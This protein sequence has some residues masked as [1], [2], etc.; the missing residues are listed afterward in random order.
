M[1]PAAAPVAAGDLFRGISAIAAEE[2]VGRVEQEL[3]EYFGTEAAFLVSSGK[4]ALA[5]IL[6]GLSRLSPRRRVVI[7]AYTCYSVPSAVLK[8]GLA[9][10][11]CDVDPDT[12]DFDFSALE[13]LADER[14]LCVLPTHLFGIPSDVAR[15]RRICGA[16]G[17]LVVED[18]AQAMG[19]VHEGRKLG[20]LGDAGF[21]SL[22]R[23]KTVT[24]GSG[25][26][27]LTSSKEIAASVRALHAALGREPSAAR[28]RSIIDAVLMRAFLNPSFYWLPDGMPFLGIGETRFLPDFPMCRLSGFKAG[29]LETWR[30]RMEEQNRCRER[31]GRYFV[32]ALG[33]RA[34]G[35]YSRAIPFLRFPV[36][37]ESPKDKTDA[38][39]SLRH[40][41]VSPMYPGSINRITELQ[42]HFAGSEYPGAERIAATLFTLPTHVLL[43]DRDRRAVCE[44]LR[45]IGIRKSNPGT[46][47]VEAS[48]YAAGRI[49]K[50]GG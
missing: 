25:G 12:L 47:P 38:C 15:V 42:D 40:L 34:E 22:G 17:I 32:D 5:L 44:G 39:A 4:A 31:N 45:R 37:A 20:T 28:A 16:R 3:R 30:A 35:I 8:A 41:G 9:I 2:A 49:R 23:G 27:I 14:T 36:V 43:T 24:C 10:E 1:P 29:M 46:F 18:A 19:V 33:L 21:F 48:A 6:K 26:V 11:L 7:P 13:R 50:S